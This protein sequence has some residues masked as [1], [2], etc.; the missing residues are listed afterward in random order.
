MYLSGFVN[1]S[2]GAPFVHV[3][4][5]DQNGNQIWSTAPDTSGDGTGIVVTGDAVY[6]KYDYTVTDTAPFGHR[7]AVRKYDTNGG[8]RWTTQPV[9]DNGNI[10]DI[11]ADRNGV[12]AIWP[13]ADNAGNGT[14]TFAY[15]YDADGNLLWTH[16]L[17]D[18]FGSTLV[19]DGDGVYILN[20][21]YD[22][23]AILTLT[24]YDDDTGGQI[25]QRQLDVT[26]ASGS[27]GY[28]YP[29]VVGDGGIILS[30][31]A[32]DANGIA[33]R[34]VA[35]KFDPTGLLEWTKD[36]APDSTWTPDGVTADSG[37]AYVAVL[38]SPPNRWSIETL[39]DTGA[40]TQ[41]VTDLA[42]DLKY[43]ASGGN[44]LYFIGDAVTGYDPTI[45][46]VAKLAG[47]QPEGRITWGPN[48]PAQQGQGVAGATVQVGDQQTQTD[49]NGFYT[50]SPF[51][52]TQTMKV[53]LP[54]NN[55]VEEPKSDPGTTTKAAPAA[56]KATGGPVHAAV[57]AD[58]S[59]NFHTEVQVT[60]SGPRPSRRISPP[61]AISFR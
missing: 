46:G 13:L 42:G 16:Q 8:V 7:S 12:T 31:S 17:P 57:E 43:F 28:M 10:F 40:I 56:T 25:W 48:F 19:A 49:A 15:H 11:A 1:D 58:I 52:G 9:T 23:R 34:P 3:R 4:K 53:T 41:T 59:A 36:L 21:Y 18:L 27:G 24:K 29:P 26:P 61:S 39:D 45:H 30:A 37:H 22:S 2:G 47:S 32:V 50:L 14:G 44:A 54:V 20:S 35:L 60:G 55:A 5:L 33:T 6:V 51:T 38:Q